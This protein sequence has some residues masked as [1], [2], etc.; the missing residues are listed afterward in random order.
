MPDKPMWYG[1][2][3]GV[4]ASLRALPY[5][6]VDRSTV[7]QLLGVRRR[8]AQQILAPCVTHTVG[9][10]GLADRDRLIAHLEQ[11]ARGDAADYERR[12]R[13]KVAGEIARLR[14]ACLDQPPVLVEAPTAIV[15]Q[16]FAGLRGVTISPGQIVVEF[17]GPQDALEK[18]LALAMAIGNDSGAFERLATRT[19]V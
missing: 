14:Q 4:I 16:T 3:D 17:D 19:S 10:N 7:E 13:R 11:L 1:Q 6:W 8:R 5:P 2:L 12:R 18:L 15:N 9:A